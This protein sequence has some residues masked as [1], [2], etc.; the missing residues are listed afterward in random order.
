[1]KE[2]K[3]NR[4]ILS[5]DDYHKDN[6]KLA[7]LLLKYNL[8]AIFFIECGTD[9]KREQIKQLANI[10][11]TIGNHSF[12]HPQDLKLLSDQDLKYEIKS[13]REVVK[14]LSEQKVEWF[15]FPRGRYDER[16]LKVVKD[17]GYRYARTTQLGV[18]GD[19]FE[20][21]CYHCFERSEYNG[22]DWLDVIKRVYDENEGNIHIW[23]HYFE[24]S[25]TGEWEKFEKLLEYITK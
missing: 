6:Y 19:R 7:E 24:L 2:Q 13:C 22:E 11:F 12:S 15:C 14:D 17:A 16:V 20:Q 4:L 21:K 9:E 1:M 5:F 25:R 3:N 8:P 10:G 18:S 23:G